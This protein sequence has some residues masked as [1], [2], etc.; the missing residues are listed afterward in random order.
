[1]RRRWLLGPVAL[2]VLMVAIVLAITNC[3][4]PQPSAGLFRPVDVVVV[5]DQ[6]WSMNNRSDPRCARVESAVAIIE[7]MDAFTAQQLGHRAAIAQFG[8]R[9]DRDEDHRVVP[10]ATL[11]RLGSDHMIEKRSL[12]ESIRCVN[13]GVTDFRNAFADAVEAFLEGRE[14]SGQRQRVIVVLTDGEP[15]YLD[16]K[17][18]PFSPQP[19]TPQLQE[20]MRAIAAHLGKLG[21][22]PPL[23][24]FVA[25]DEKDEFWSR[26]AP[27]WQK[28][29]DGAYGRV[30]PA[31]EAF[32][33]AVRSIQAAKDKLV[34]LAPQILGVEGECGAFRDRV[35]VPPHTDKL[36]VF[37][38]KGARPG[39]RVQLK[40]G[41]EPAKELAQGTG[42]QLLGAARPQPGR[43]NLS[44]TPADD[45]PHLNMCLALAGPLVS[46][47][48]PPSTVGSGQPFDV[49]AVRVQFADGAAADGSRAQPISVEAQAHSSGSERPGWGWQDLLKIEGAKGLWISQPRKGPSPALMAKG[50]EDWTLDVKVVAADVVVRRTSFIVRVRGDQPYFALLP[51]DGQ[52]SLQLDLRE[53]GQSVADA[54]GRFGKPA[55]KI[56]SADV[57]D[58]RRAPSQSP[59]PLLQHRG[60]SRFELGRR[61]PDQ[62]GQ[63][64]M[65]RIRFTDGPLQWLAL[66]R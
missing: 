18:D 17:G 66:P 62:S 50:G 60:E 25:L 24:Y 1:M 11:T 14:G 63:D 35:D 42:F 27:E 55:N 49:L 61:L 53:D 39:A 43:W 12:I 31:G 48:Y 10:K 20:Y 28:L 6:S 30:T 13:M 56:A 45:A 47:E 54:A 29:I 58:W 7:V 3:G 33:P 32:F 46:L 51:G 4:R 41:G 52:R 34:E 38:N 57:A 19:G 21:D 15:T 23:L 9:T 65:V 40:K 5:V 37:I 36:A 44:V 2:G 22:E 8:T 59:G 16:A 64:R 26:Y